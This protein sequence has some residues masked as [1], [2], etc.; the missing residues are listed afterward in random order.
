MEK[1]ILSDGK[2]IT[3]YRYLMEQKIGR[4]LTS[5]EA[6]HHI[7]SNHEDNRIEN[8]QLMTRSEHASLHGRQQKGSGKS[9]EEGLCDILV[10]DITED[11]K[12]TLK[13]IAKKNKRSLNN[14]ILVA[15]ENYIEINKKEDIE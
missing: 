12:E 1:T 14:E 15:I 3:Y 10:R 9:S 5:D 11:D 7:N 8:L 13:V 6:V 2:Y 4:K